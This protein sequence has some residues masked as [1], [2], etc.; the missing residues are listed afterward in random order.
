MWGGGKFLSGGGPATKYGT[1][2]PFG[3]LGRLTGNS[4][5]VGLGGRG[6]EIGNEADNQPCGNQNRIDRQ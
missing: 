3:E 2:R 5:D 6:P 4:A 1:D